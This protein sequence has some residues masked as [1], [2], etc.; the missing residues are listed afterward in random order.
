MSSTLYLAIMLGIVIVVFVISVPVMM[1]K[2]CPECGRRN[3][4]DAATCRHCQA[5]LPEQPEDG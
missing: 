3:G 5:S 1:T 4:L 2:K